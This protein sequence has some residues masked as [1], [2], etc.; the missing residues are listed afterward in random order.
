M[1]LRRSS[2]LSQPL[3]IRTCRHI[4]A[5]GRHCQGAAVRGRACCRHHLDARTRLH[6][7]A[8]ARR[9]TLILRLRVP[10]TRRDLARNRAE[11]SRVVA[12]GRMDFYTARML[13]WAMDL[14][15]AVL[16]TERASR[17]RRTRKP[18]VSYHVPLNPLF[19]GSCTE[20]PSQVPENTRGEGRGCHRVGTG[21]WPT[22]R[23]VAHNCPPLAIAGLAPIAAIARQPITPLE[24]RSNRVDYG[25]RGTSIEP[26]PTALQS[27]PPIFVSTCPVLLL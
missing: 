22:Y 14:T 10:D 17:P 1:N 13:F 19:A 7:M 27:R 8:R 11:I 25:A 2:M 23:E 18:N 24:S 12:T 15:A 5:G 6:N 3:I 9:R 21:W 20:N 26:E 16:P 4:L